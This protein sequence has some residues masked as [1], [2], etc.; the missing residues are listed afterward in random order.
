MLKNHGEEFI[1]FAKEIFDNKNNNQ[2]TYYKNRKIFNKTSDQEAIYQDAF[3]SRREFGSSGYDPAE[4]KGV[5]GCV[6]EKVKPWFTFCQLFCIRD[7]EDYCDYYVFCDYQVDS[8][9]G[10]VISWKST[11]VAIGDVWCGLY[12]PVITLFADVQTKVRQA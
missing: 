1:I 12:E 3:T 4:N 7:G 2:R 8:Q 10:E 11:K 5:Y 9:Y 6:L